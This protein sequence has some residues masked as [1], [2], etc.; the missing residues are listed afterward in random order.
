MPDQ[1][2]SSRMEKLWEPT[3]PCL[4]GD[5]R[6]ISGTEPTGSGPARLQ[7]GTTATNTDTAEPPDPSEPLGPC[8]QNDKHLPDPHQPQ[9]SI[10]DGFSSL[11]QG[12]GK[13]RDSNQGIKSFLAPASR[14][15]LCLCAQTI[16]RS[17]RVCVCGSSAIPQTPSMTNRWLALAATTAP[18]A[19]CGNARS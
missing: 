7:E 11:S 10:S 9:L 19:R 18:A 17:S 6:L 5:S 15:G 1:G 4:H 8:L 13:P 16:T 12:R 14:S 2:D 3:G